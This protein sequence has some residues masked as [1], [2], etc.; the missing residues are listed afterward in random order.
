M[1]TRWTWREERTT[2][3]G[4]FA[5]GAPRPGAPSSTSTERSLAPRVAQQSDDWIAIRDSFARVRREQP[6][7]HTGRRPVLSPRP[8]HQ[9]LLARGVHQLF[10]D[11]A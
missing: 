5:P 6:L 3:P 4:R 11:G 10:S 1:P 9:A 8:P 2:S 7:A